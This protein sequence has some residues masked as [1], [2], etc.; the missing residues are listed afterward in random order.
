[1]FDLV[2]LDHPTTISSF[3][4]GWLSSSLRLYKNKLLHA[5]EYFLQEQLGG[6]L[7]AEHSVLTIHPVVSAVAADT[8]KTLP[9]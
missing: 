2:Q 4:G 1:M 9:S 8:S 6:P 5:K 7:Q 3:L